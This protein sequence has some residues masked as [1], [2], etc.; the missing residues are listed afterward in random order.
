MRRVAFESAEIFRYLIPRDLARRRLLRPDGRSSLLNRLRAL[1]N[2]LVS[3]KRL[4]GIP[5]CEK[6]TEFGENLWVANNS[7]KLQKR[8]LIGLKERRDQRRR[9]IKDET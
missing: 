5:P 2:D 1:V 4:R 9:R 6:A 7:P 3:G 8:A